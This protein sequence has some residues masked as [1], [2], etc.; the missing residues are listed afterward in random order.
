MNILPDGFSFTTTITLAMLTNHY[1]VKFIPIAYSRR[2]GKS[3]I[4]PFHDTMNF[5]QMIVRIS[6]TSFALAA[7]RASL[8]RWNSALK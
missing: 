1:R 8:M 5:I 2:K 4:H 6:E 7:P 3:K